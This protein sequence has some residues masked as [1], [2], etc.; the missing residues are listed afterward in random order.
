ML[1]QGNTDSQISAPIRKGGAKPALSVECI[2]IQGNAD[3]ISVSLDQVVEAV[4]SRYL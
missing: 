1:I 2:L 4:D 3:L